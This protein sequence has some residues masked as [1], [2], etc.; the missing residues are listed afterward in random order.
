M[1]S[2]DKDFTVSAN[3]IVFA[4]NTMAIKHLNRA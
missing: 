4:T 1:Q 3:G 2:L